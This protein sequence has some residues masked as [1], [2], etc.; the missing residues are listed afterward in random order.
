M[1]LEL[2]TTSTTEGD[3]EELTYVFK[4]R[5]NCADEVGGLISVLNL[6]RFTFLDRKV[7]DHLYSTFRG[8]IMYLDPE[9][10][11]NNDD[12]HEDLGENVDNEVMMIFL[13]RQLCC[14]SLGGIKKVFELRDSIPITE[15]AFARHA[16]YG[17]IYSHK[18]TPEDECLHRSPLGERL[19]FY[20][21][22]HPPPNLQKYKLNYEQKPI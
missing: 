14:D 20:S 8:V 7:R 3:A 22:A 12:L 6:L 9:D 15:A 18:N 10:Q 1:M 4:S 16:K 21:K 13:A 17:H 11:Y 2:L 5:F 19:R